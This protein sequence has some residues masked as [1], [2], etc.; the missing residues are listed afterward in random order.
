MAKVNRFRKKLTAPEVHFE[1]GSYY[2]GEFGLWVHNRWCQEVMSLRQIRANLQAT[3]PA[4]ERR[5]AYQQA[6]KGQSAAS[7]ELAPVSV[8]PFNPLGNKAYKK[9]T[10]PEEQ[11]VFLEDYARQ[12]AGQQEALGKL[13]V[14]EYLTARAQYKALGR[15]PAADALQENLGNEFQS[16]IKTSLLKNMLE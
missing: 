16:G 6:L 11:R 1:T 14:D 10:T 8:K 9:L 15:N 5:M 3:S 4:A 7:A 13:T 2:V 12:L